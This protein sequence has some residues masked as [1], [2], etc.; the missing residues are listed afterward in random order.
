MPGARL[1]LPFPVVK[2][3]NGIEPDANG[4]ITI[5]VTGESLITITPNDPIE[6]SDGD[7]HIN[8]STWDVFYKESGSW[9]LKGNIKPE[10]SGNFAEY[11]HREDIHIIADPSTT[12]IVLAAVPTGDIPITLS[13]NGLIQ[14]PDNYMIVGNIVHLNDI[15]QGDTIRIHYAYRR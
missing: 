4:N 12:F 5:R 14:Q 10:P 15:F 9:T 13:I 3:V 6:G 7:L 11:I 8:N 1:K 2:S